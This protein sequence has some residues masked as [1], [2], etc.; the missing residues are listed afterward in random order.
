ML[1]PLR[2]VSIAGFS[3]HKIGVLIPQDEDGQRRS[4]ISTTC[5]ACS[6]MEHLYPLHGGTEYRP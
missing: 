1:A 4:S 2:I 6:L 3:D 5:N